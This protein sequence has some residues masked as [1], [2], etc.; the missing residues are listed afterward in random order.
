MIWAR[1]RAL[2]KGPAP[3]RSR[4]QIAASAVELADAEGLEAVSMRRVAMMLGIGAASLYRYLES[5]DELYDP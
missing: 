1:P 4:A 2:P 5:K 3:S